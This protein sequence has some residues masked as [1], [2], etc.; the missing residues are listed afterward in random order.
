[1]GERDTPKTTSAK[2]RSTSARK[3]AYVD[4]FKQ[5]SLSTPDT[6]VP[7]AHADVLPG[8]N[9][10]IVL[11]VEDVVVGACPE[12]ARTPRHLNGR[13]CF[14]NRHR[15]PSTRLNGIFVVNL[16]AI[17]EKLRPDKMGGR[18]TPKTSAKKRSTSARKNAYVDVPGCRFRV[19]ATYANVL[20]DIPPFGGG[21]K[22]STIDYVQ[23][24][25][26]TY[27]RHGA[28]GG[29]EKGRGRNQR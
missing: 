20:A 17:Q 19:R 14:A 26:H 2:R 24:P 16:I 10:R 18:D 8:T 28:D 23:Q 5:T 29:W 22:K 15:Q 7:N 13:G 9:G 3:N 6:N 12:H 1:M 21:W 4:V 11:D 27:G 25:K